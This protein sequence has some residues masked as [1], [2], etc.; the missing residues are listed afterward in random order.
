MKSPT[1]DGHFGV[2][3]VLVPATCRV[4]GLKQMWVTWT[5]GGD[6][7][8]VDSDVGGVFAGSRGG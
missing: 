4:V 7:S 6:I 3:V 8:V 1:F 5:R 2:V